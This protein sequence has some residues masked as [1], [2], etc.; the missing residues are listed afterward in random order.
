MKEKYITIFTPTYNR[1]STLRRLYKSIKSQDY[2][3][4]E[5]LIVDDGSVDE[6]AAVV[7]T[8]MDD[9]SFA[10]SYYRKNNGGKHTA[11]NYAL[12]KAN[13][14]YFFTVD[15]DDIIPAN[16]LSI[17]A[18]I[19]AE[20]DIDNTICGIVGLKSYFDNSIIGRPF[21]YERVST[22]YQIHND[23]EDGERSFII[24]TDILRNF[25]FAEINGEKFLG[26]VYVYDKISRQYGFIVKNMVL[27]LC[28]YQE[29][30]LSV[31]Y[32]N[33]LLKNPI[34]SSMIWI[35]R[36]D[37]SV[38]FKERLRY[39]I[40]YWTYYYFSPRK[41]RVKYSGLNSVLV[42]LC[43]IPGYIYYLY[44]RCKF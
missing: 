32:A 24:R 27:T 29:D 19:L 39:A 41:Q 3:D 35:G 43:F 30:G 5:W 14:K 18:K 26:E 2:N 17:M 22:L 37:L 21:S 33:L 42:G 4:F 7:K 12:N 38:S 34:G 13:G 31:N 10:I 44:N 36:I 40:K 8:F 23:G 16:A 15:S 1:A 25:P 9:A 20:V 28:E 6:T 11:H